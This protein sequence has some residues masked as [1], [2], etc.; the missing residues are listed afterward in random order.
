[1]CSLGPSARAN[2][3]HPSARARH[4]A[5]PAPAHAA[6]SS[7]RCRAAASGGAS[8][9]APALATLLAPAADGASSTT[10]ASPRPRH[11]SMSEQRG[12][13]VLTCDLL[14]PRR[15]LH[16]AP[17][18]WPAESPKAHHVGRRGGPFRHRGDSLRARRV[19]A[20][21]TLRPR[22]PAPWRRPR[23]RLNPSG[24]S[25]P[26]VRARRPARLDAS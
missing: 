21:R 18:V 3:H 9:T 26:W 8:S 4:S 25:R 13:V 19:G 16:V 17:S 5:A 12:R 23:H 15:A 6:A 20:W 14:H 2:L 22:E 1:M 11:V 10:S 24:R 7:A